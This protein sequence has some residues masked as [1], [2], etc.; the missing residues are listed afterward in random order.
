M[1]EHGHGSESDEELIQLCKKKNNTDAKKKLYKKYYSYSFSIALRYG[2]TKESA[3]EIVNDSFMKAFSNIQT[4]ETGRSFKSWFRKIIINTAIDHSRKEKKHIERVPLGEVSLPGNYENIIS[5]LTVQDI[6]SLLKYLPENQR[7]VFN[8][9]EIENFSHK[10]IG[11]KLAIT[12]STSRSYL[13][14]AK[15]NLRELFALKFG[16]RNE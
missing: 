8:L 15:T 16:E 14:R 2:L 12:T 6:L 1:T 3:A 5:K 9:Y 13:T 10:E 4:F 11:E 7:L